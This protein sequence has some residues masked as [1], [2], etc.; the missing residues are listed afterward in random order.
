MGGTSEQTQGKL[1]SLVREKRGRLTQPQVA[2]QIGISTDSLRK[3]ERG[4]YPLPVRPRK[5]GTAI[6]LVANWLKRDATALVNEC[7]SP[8]EVARSIFDV[9]LTLD[10]ESS[11]GSYVA[12]LPEDRSALISMGALLNAHAMAYLIALETQFPAFEFLICNIPPFF[13]FADEEYIK[14]GSVSVELSDDDQTIYEQLIFEHQDRVRTAVQAGRKHTRIVLHMKSFVTFLNSLPAV[15]ARRQVDLMIHYL[16]YDGFDLLLHDQAEEFEEEFEVLSCH[17]PFGARVNGDTVSIR[18]RHVGLGT[19]LVYQLAVIGTDRELVHKD[20]VRAEAIWR[21]ALE[22]YAGRLS[23][24]D[25]Q[26]RLALRQKQ[27]TSAL[28]ESAYR[29]AHPND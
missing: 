17:Y 16:Q 26:D 8:S 6:E 3:I 19:T 9:Q 2:R 29:A 10:A 5:D 25:G 22:A 18:H 27:I 28:L 1:A 14:Y 12:A 11:L 23:S 4:T 21:E 20:F 15:R 24:S 13:L 7:F